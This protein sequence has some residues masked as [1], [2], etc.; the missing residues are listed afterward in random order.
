MSKSLVAFNGM[1]EK[2]CTDLLRRCCGSS[3]WVCR[4]AAARPFADWAAIGAVADRI[5]AELDPA[6]WQEAFAH[7]PMIG[8]LAA[9]RARFARTGA[10]AQSEQGQVQDAEEAILRDLAV[11]NR[12]YREKFGYIFIVCATGKSAAEMLSLLQT[13]LSNDP[14]RELAVA[15]EQQRQITRIRLDKVRA[16]LQAAVP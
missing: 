10:W 11:G 9:V 12:T 15:A 7:H 6:D 3:R 2:A 5:W 16:D 4:M 1:A 13:R 14:V 8:D